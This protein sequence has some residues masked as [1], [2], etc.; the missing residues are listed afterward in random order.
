MFFK[1][2]VFFKNFNPPPPPH[3]YELQIKNKNKV[4]TKK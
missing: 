4:S 2:K 3:I 1:K